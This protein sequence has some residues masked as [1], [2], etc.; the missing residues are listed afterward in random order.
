MA[1]YRHH[2]YMFKNWCRCVYV[3]VHL[4]YPVEEIVIL[5]PHL[6]HFTNHIN[7]FLYIYYTLIL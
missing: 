1:R 7:L 6:F 3:F 5:Q 4:I 2:T